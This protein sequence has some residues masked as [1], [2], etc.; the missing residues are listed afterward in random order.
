MIHLLFFGIAQDLVN[1]HK[2]ELKIDKPLTVNELKVIL[3]EKFPNLSKFP[4]FAVAV[5]EEYATENTQ[6]ND[7]DVVA[8]IPPVSGG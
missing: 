7:T 3:F 1:Q 5:N 2:I 4:S 8:I 6:I